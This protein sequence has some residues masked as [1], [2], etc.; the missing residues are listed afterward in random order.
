DNLEQNVKIVS[1]E[2]LS[3]M[4]HSKEA[5]EHIH[6]H[7]AYFPKNAQHSIQQYLNTRKVFIHTNKAPFRNPCYREDNE[8]K[9]E[10]TQTAYHQTLKIHESLPVDTSRVKSLQHN[11][12]IP[13]LANCTELFSISDTYNFIMHPTKSVAIENEM[14][15]VGPM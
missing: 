6:L 9:V 13:L 1:A 5:S 2:N 11:K 15:S 10:L 4:L 14:G 8:W 7:G 3:T 12:A